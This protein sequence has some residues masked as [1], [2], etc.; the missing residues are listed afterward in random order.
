MKN[1]ILLVILRVHLQ[2]LGAH[3]V[4]AL[5]R[6]H[7]HNL[8]RKSSLEAGSTREERAR[9][10]G[11]TQEIPRGSLAREARYVGGA[12]ACIPNGKAEWFYHPNLL[13]FGT[14]QRTLGNT[15]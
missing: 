5:A 4:T 2:K 11:E 7:V 15:S 14:V 3:L 10:S 12:R 8:A 1:R 13:S 6:L 9:K